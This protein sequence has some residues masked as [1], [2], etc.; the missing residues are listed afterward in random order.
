MSYLTEDLKLNTMQKKAVLH[1]NGPA[2]VLAIPG[3]G[4][5]TL[6]ICRTLHLINKHNV[7]PERILSLTFSKSAALDMNNRYKE[8]FT[9]SSY[10]I[11]FSTIHRFCYGVLLR[12]FKSV[13][14]NYQLLESKE[15]PITK[16]RLLQDIYS[17]VNHDYLTDD[18]YEE[19]NTGIGYVKNMM[20]DSEKY[21]S[22]I[23]KFADI[24]KMYESYKKE[25]HLID[26]D[27]MLTMC[28]TLFQKKP[29][30]LKNYQDRFDYI[31]VDEC[32]DTS[33]VQHKIIELLGKKHQNV[34]MVADDDQS[35]YGFR[36][37]CPEIIVNIDKYYPG[38]SKYVL[39]TNYRSSHEIVSLCQDI[40]SKNTLRHDKDSFGNSKDKA[41][42]E[43]IYVDTSFEQASYII[44]SYKSIDTSQAVLYRNN[45]S[46][47]ALADQLDRQD[48]D[49]SLKD[50]KNTFFNHWITLDMIAF[51]K[52][53]LIPN[54][55]KSFERVYFKMNA[56]LS[57]EQMYYIQNNFDG[58]NLF[59]CMTTLKNLPA[60]KQKTFNKVKVNFEYLSQLKPELALHFIEDSLD[61]KAY[62]NQQAKRNNSPLSS[63]Q[64]YLDILKLIAKECLSISDFLQR[65]D[66]L[67]SIIYQASKNSNP[68]AL[69]LLTMHASKGLEFDYI[70]LTDLDQD[71]FPS[72]WAI[73]QESEGDQQPIEEERRLFYVALSRSKYGI[74]LIQ[75]KF[76]NGQYIKA[77]SFVKEFLNGGKDNI[78]IKHYKIET[79]ISHLKGFEIGDQVLHTSF[80]VGQLLDLYED[81]VV[82]EFKDST[83]TLSA[84][85]CSDKKILMK[86]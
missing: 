13:N 72:K 65:L 62:L 60:F 64:K 57:K 43:L 47:I 2:L 7:L 73:D 41:L 33:K 35:I 5:T 10:N 21:P 24:F 32:Q 74:A 42:L 44:K 29:E 30:I 8:L 39:E 1:K 55:V 12:Y 75:T 66:T 16:Y 76:K 81:R 22:N 80:G 56:Y 69:K 54:D 37:A 51:L 79:P 20:L 27:D 61:Y 59:D 36:G 31:Q 78:Q 26:F 19:L 18:S 3:S 68:Y 38:I 52:L 17:Q 14:K 63:F 53:A 84:Q 71:L 50:I 67:K 83:K 28:L 6:L 9:N 40:I 23:N 45:L 4:K 48:V 11:S 77:S 15:S 25:N 49:F 58:I 85:L 70:Y 46:M 86:V 82:I 34:F